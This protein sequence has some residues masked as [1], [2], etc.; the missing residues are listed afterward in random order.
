MGIVTSC[1][2]AIR[3]VTP[4]PEPQGSPAP[5]RAAA[6]EPVRPGRR[7]LVGEM[8]PLGAAGRPSLAPLLLRGV[9]WTDEPAEVGA[10]ISHGEATRFT[11]FGVD[12]K[13]AGVFEALGL[14]EVGLPQVVAAGSYAGAGPCTRAGASSVRLEEP[15]CQPA[16]RGCGIAVAALGDKV[17]TWEWKAGGACTSGD[18]LAIDVDGDG[19]VEAFPIAGLLDAVRGPA[20]SLEAR[21]QAVTCA[22]SFAV[23]GLRI[24]P[25]PE[26][27]KAADPRYVVLVDVLAV[28][29]FDDDG[30]REVVLGLRYPDQRT[31]AIYGAGESPSTLQLIG[32]ATSWVR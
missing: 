16:T 3:P 24:A 7:I 20:E 30:R 5:P 9:Q 21:A 2:P 11:V 27:G 10:A 25:P 28:V 12:G 23:F 19:V 22:P 14:A 17:D 15:A 6:A 8:C 32:E 26:N 1:G 29:D 4:P 31:I 18:V 13:R